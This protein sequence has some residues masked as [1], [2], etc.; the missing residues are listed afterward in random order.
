MCIRDSFSIYKLSA[1]AEQLERLDAADEPWIQALI[2]RIR[3]YRQQH[4]EQ[5]IIYDSIESA[6]LALDMPDDCYLVIRRPTATHIARITLSLIH[7][8][9]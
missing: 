3:A 8:S 6:L 7:I 9:S 5:T 4:P 1:A 2:E